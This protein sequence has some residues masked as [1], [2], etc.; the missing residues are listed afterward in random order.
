[1][2]PKE[3]TTPEGMHEGEGKQETPEEK[4]IEQPDKGGIDA[5]KDQDDTETDQAETVEDKAD[6]PVQDEMTAKSE[7][8]T[9]VARKDEPEAKEVSEEET[10]KE[11]KVVEEKPEETETVKKDQKE[12]D[13]DDIEV[14]I[15][16]GT[17]NISSGFVNTP[18]FGA[19][20][21]VTIHYKIKEW[22][23]ERIQQFKGVVLQRK[24][25][26][27]TETVTVRK[28]SG[29]IGIER[30]IPLHSPFIEKIE[31]NKKGVVR[32]ARIFY[33]RKLKG[34]KARIAERKK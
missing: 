33:L 34:K 22:N 10:G 18:A 23:K 31:V 32:R 9:P 1:M 2:N 19:G 12:N 4:S 6:E 5:V 3:E 20:D 25:E 27:A 17:I 28:V 7:E 16:N 26:G 13:K 14:I 15:Q 24:G 29:G 11:E 30:I 21:T 8:K